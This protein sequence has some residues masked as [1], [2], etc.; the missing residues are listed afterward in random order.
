MSIA[1]LQRLTDAAAADGNAPAPDRAALPTITGTDNGDPRLRATIIQALSRIQDPELP[2]NIVD[3]GLIYTLDISPAANGA[4][5]QVSIRMTLTAPA[6]PVAQSFPGIVSAAL[7]K[8]DGV[9]SAEVELVWQPPWSRE[10]MSR[11]ARYATG[12]W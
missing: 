10:R 4:G 11:R 6:C 8:L 12:L 9:E 3:L 2:V 1:Q 7:Q 5:A